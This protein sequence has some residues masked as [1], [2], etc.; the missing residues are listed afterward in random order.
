M[1]LAPGM[2]PD[3]AAYT[4]KVHAKFPGAQPALKGVILLHAMEDGRL[5]AILESTYLTALRTGYAG[6]LGADLLA[7][8]DASSVAI[9]GA[10]A[11]GALQLE[12]LTA[13]RRIDQVAVFDTLG[14]RAEAFASTQAK[15]LGLD[16][17]PKGSVAEAVVDAD[18]IVT[19]TWAREA[20][21]F[22]DMV[23]KGAHITSLGPDQPG[24]AEL[25]ADLILKSKF[26]A[27]DRR[28]A[29]EMGAI[30]GVGLGIEAIHAE[31]G[32]V[33]AG[34]KPG[35]ESPEEITLFGAV[36]LPFQDLAVAWPAYREAVERKI[37]R[38][39]AFLG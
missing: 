8:P 30:G 25:S 39:I 27:D 1:L 6:A 22:P 26:V 34:L 13:V 37:G 29:V 18:I 32:E 20:F 24:K 5:L 3:V 23:K 17:V 36:G 2:L 33:I 21:L 11:Q 7:N 28:L 31:L 16:I 38:S 9:I 14:E 10:G 35:R 12:C 19:A 4:V 15:R